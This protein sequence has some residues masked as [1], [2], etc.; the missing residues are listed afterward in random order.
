MALPC[1]VCP[2]RTEQGHHRRIPRE[3]SYHKGASWG[4]EGDQAEKEEINLFK[5]KALQGL[6]ELPLA[7]VR[8]LQLRLE[9]HF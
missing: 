2:T 6:E 4:G 5:A 9:S 8:F 7:I 3:E 1:P